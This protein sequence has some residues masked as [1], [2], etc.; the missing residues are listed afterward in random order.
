MATNHIYHISEDGGITTFKPRPSPSPFPGLEADVVFGIEERLLHNYLLPRDCPRVTFY[1]GKNTSAEDRQQFMYTATADYII[2]IE[3][4]WLPVIEKTT[5]Y[6]YEF[7]ATPFTVL[8]ECAGYY[9]AYTEVKPVSVKRID[10]ILQ[11]LT[12]R[13]QVELRVVPNLWDVAEKV[14]KSTMQFSLIRMR[15]ATAPAHK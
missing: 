5:L 1:A 11:E 8:D 14:K 12:S 13:Q 4:A 7:D 15:N 9:V 3:T 2:I 6:C 10:N